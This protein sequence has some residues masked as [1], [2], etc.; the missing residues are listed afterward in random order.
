MQVV[1]AWCR[2]IVNADNDVPFEHTTF[3]GGAIL[4]ERYDQDSSFNLKIIVTHHSAWQRNVL[5]GKAD[6]T[7]TDFPVAD[8]A[9]GNELGG[10]NRSG[11]TNSL[12][13][14]YHRRV[15]P[16]HFSARVN[17]RPAGISG[18]EC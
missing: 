11:K 18:I 5:S 4:L 14:Q 9:A 16:D 7:P 3:S 12:C 2:V 1:D 15:H 17:Q 10:I 6:I 8:Q 13:R